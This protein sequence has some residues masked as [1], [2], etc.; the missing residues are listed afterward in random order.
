MTC[1]NGP[2]SNDGLGFVLEMV[3][4]LL[5]RPNFIVGKYIVK[6]GF[7]SDRLLPFGNVLLGLNNLPAE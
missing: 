5:L 3:C 6:Y 7:L 4:L 2:C 1:C